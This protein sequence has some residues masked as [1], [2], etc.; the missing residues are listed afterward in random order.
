MIRDLV[1]K[2]VNFE[3]GLLVLTRDK[4]RDMVD[5]LIRR[6]EVSSEQG[7]KMV[8]DVLARGEESKRQVRSEI[9]GMIKDVLSRQN[10]PTRAEFNELKNE[11]LELRAELV[12]VEYAD[13]EK[14]PVDIQD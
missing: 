14:E 6:G 1:E 8:E 7:K 10:L 11:V 3:L 4:V 13:P 5:D 12:K 2:A 9:D